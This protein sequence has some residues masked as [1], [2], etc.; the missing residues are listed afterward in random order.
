MFY[1]TLS[2]VIFYEILTF[3]RQTANFI[4][5]AS[6]L[7]QSK[8]LPM[9]ALKTTGIDINLVLTVTYSFIVPM[10][11]VFDFCNCILPICKRYTIINNLL[12]YI[13]FLDIC[14]K[15]GFVY[16]VKASII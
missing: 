10:G 8:F 16:N 15:R 1:I 4:H 11:L 14:Q 9:H 13:R 12:T 6:K 5:S 2:L 7:R 3:Q